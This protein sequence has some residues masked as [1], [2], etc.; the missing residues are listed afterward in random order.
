[1]RGGDHSASSP[2]ATERGWNVTQRR[3]VSRHDYPE[4]NPPG[5]SAPGAGEAGR[6]QA[7][8]PAIPQWVKEWGFILLAV[9][10]LI[11]SAMIADV[12]HAHG[13]GTRWFLFFLLLAAGAGAWAWDYGRRLGGA[14]T[15]RRLKLHGQ[16]CLDA[17]DAMTGH[18]LEFYYAQLLESLGWTRI[19]VTGD[20]SGGDGAAD[21][22]A[23]DPRNRDFA[24][25]C[26]RYVKTSP[27]PP[28]VRAG[29]CVA[30]GI[31]GQPRTASVLSFSPAVAR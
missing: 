26:M 2:A 23:T 12:G 15:T 1:L 17:V 19:Q 8:V 5:R 29:A 31:H 22:L 3:Y 27:C 28:Y 16:S 25:Q 24:I 30:S 4:T 6:A 10:F 20:K 9:A 13:T 11:L 7:A 14:R 18:Q 21:I